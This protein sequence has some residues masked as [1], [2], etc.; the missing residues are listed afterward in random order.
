MAERKSSSVLS[1]Y[2]KL[3]MEAWQKWD[4]RGLVLFS[5]TLQIVLS[6]L[7]GRRK[8]KIHPFFK[9]VLWFAYLGADWIAIATLGKLSGSYTESPD[10][11]VL[12]AYWAPLLLLHLGGP[13]TITAYSF[14]DN[15]LWIRHLLI[16]VVKAI[17]VVYVICLSW[18]FSWI[19]LLSFPLI[20]A[21]IIKYVEKIL[22]LKQNNS[23]KTKPV[24]SN[25][26]N[27]Q[28]P[29][30]N[31][32]SALNDHLKANQNVLGGYLLF[33]IMRP[34]VNDYLSSHNVFDVRKRLK[35]YIKETTG[36][37][38]TRA[39]NL[40]D[41]FIPGERKKSI[42]AVDFLAAEIGFIFDVVYTKAALIYTKLGCLLR[43]T[44]FASSLSVLLLFFINIINEPK[45]HFSRIDI[46]ITGI[47]LSG[48]IALDLYAACVMLSSDWAI[49]VV[50]F[51]DIVFVRKI[52]KVA[53]KCFPCLLRRSERW[54][55]QM[56]QFDLLEYCWRYNK[57]K[58][59]QPW[60]ILLK[61]TN[62]RE[63]VEMW[64]KYWF[65]K[66]VEVPDYLKE[67]DNYKDLYNSFFRKEGFK[68]TRGEKA[69]QHAQQFDELKWSI[70]LDY[71]HSIIVWHLATSVCCS[72]EDHDDDD[73]MKKTSKYVSDYM[74]YLL[75]MCPALI[76][77]EHSKSFWLDHTYDKLKGLELPTTNSRNAASVLLS[78][79]D[80]VPKEDIE[81]SEPR[82]E[83]ES[84][85]SE[86]TFENIQEEVLQLVRVLKQSRNKWELIRNVWMEMLCYAAFSSQHIS[87]LKQLGEGIEF[88]S[89]LWL[90]P[91]YGVMRD[92][93]EDN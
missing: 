9:T 34:D 82:E 45:F 42:S 47:L 52:F 20:L 77:P 40:C 11:N 65:T 49:L 88:L 58:V 62:G 53:L 41:F 19:S 38:R 33:I 90:L 50:Q 48:A 73:D 21:G 17:F 35:A 12:R 83:L 59:N 10:I 39:I 63:I 36:L 91:S 27:S 7:G 14:E 43:F 76:L 46:G 5:L 79:Q 25:I 16:L 72:Q 24:I 85:C 89:I 23:Q 92:F 54:S 32:S 3:L 2:P 30:T 29:Q 4:V 68:I 31:N 61:I 55:N 66:F 80:N 8:Y 67:G 44:S 37:D 15:K 69:I 70:E 13:D 74:M 1:S 87:H 60:G 56:G 86:R 71:D 28:G 6:V 84:G 81:S 26:F 78:H 75:A 18:T 22:C 93:L 57:R 64:H 51:H